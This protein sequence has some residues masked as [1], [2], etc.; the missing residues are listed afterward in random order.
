MQL[1][2]QNVLLTGM[3]Y[4]AQN[5]SC[6]NHFA[7]IISGNLIISVTLASVKVIGNSKTEQIVFIKLYYT[8]LK[9]N[10]LPCFVINKDSF[11]VQDMVSNF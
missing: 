11:K 8:S 4:G 7:R 1:T 2:F 10:K 6:N 3:E 5:V 9:W